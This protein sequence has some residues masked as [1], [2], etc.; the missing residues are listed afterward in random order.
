MI[1]TKQQ[2]SNKRTEIAKQMKT[3]YVN[4][5]PSDLGTLIR[6]CFPDTASSDWSRNNNTACKSSA[7]CLASGHCCSGCV[8][9]HWQRILGRNSVSGRSSAIAV[10]TIKK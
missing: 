6:H 7:V 5:Y 1:V 9:S 10:E 2:Q 8:V 4:D 3:G